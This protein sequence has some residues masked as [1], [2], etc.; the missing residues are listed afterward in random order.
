M[1]PLDGN[2]DILPPQYAT[3]TESDDLE[4]DFDA[5]CYFYRHPDEINPD[6]SLGF[7]EWHPPQPM[8]IPPPTT[9]YEAE[10]EALAPRSVKPGEEECLSAY[11]TQDKREEALLSIR[12]TAEWDQIK[13]DLIYREFPRVC[14]EI[15]SLY[16]LYTK[17]RDRPDPDWLASRPEM[18]PTPDTSRQSTPAQE[19]SGTEAIRSTEFNTTDP[20]V[21]LEGLEQALGSTAPS[22]YS[23]RPSRSHSRA[24][25]RAHSRASS[26]CSQAGEKIT[27]PRPLAPL[28]DEKQEDILAALGVTGSP[29]LVYQTPG[30]ALGAPPSQSRPGSAAPPSRRGS[31][32]NSV[33]S[34]SGWAPPL[35]SSQVNG[36][37]YMREGSP[38]DEVEK[39]PRPKSSKG[40]MDGGRKRSHG[41]FVDANVIEEEDEEDTPRPKE[42]MQRFGNPKGYILKA[43]CP[44]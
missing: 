12:Q 25:S 36:Q 16:E 35:S 40:R 39:T 26:V 38:M 24:P 15:V 28:R 3:F 7:I 13:E 41:E 8:K 14:D 20:S 10:L 9:F 30:P 6:L 31:R 32:H 11:Y 37:S 18:T 21:A 23:R 19:L 27:R 42:K 33:A 4:E 2:G 1:T 34:N 44:A 22:Q 5:E 17:W 29:K 43:S